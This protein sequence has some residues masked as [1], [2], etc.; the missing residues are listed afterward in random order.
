MKG[1]KIFSV[2]DGKLVLIFLFPING[3][4]FMGTL[5]NIVDTLCGISSGS[6]LFDETKSD[7]LVRSSCSQNNFCRKSLKSVKNAFLLCF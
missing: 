2:F 4:L 5:K 6:A 3:Y 7:D 1:N